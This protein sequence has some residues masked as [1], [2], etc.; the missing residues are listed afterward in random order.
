MEN[1]LGFVVT[2]VAMSNFGGTR[3]FTDGD[4]GDGLI[5]MGEANGRSA[6][7]RSRPC[8]N[9]CAGSRLNSERNVDDEL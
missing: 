8:W 4:S 7:T 5:L 3:A 1:R 9:A 6:L 2:L